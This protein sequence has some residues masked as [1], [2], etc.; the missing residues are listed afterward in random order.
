MVRLFGKRHQRNEKV[1]AGVIYCGDAVFVLCTWELLEVPFFQ[2]EI[3]LQI[4]RIHVI[5]RAALYVKQLISKAGVS[6]KSSCII[7]HLLSWTHIYC[8]LLTW[9]KDWPHIYGCYCHAILICSPFC[10]GS[11]AYCGAWMVLYVCLVESESRRL[12]RLCEWGPPCRD[13]STHILTIS[14]SGLL[15]LPPRF[16]QTPGTR[17]I[18]RGGHWGPYR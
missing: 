4:S 17:L 9:S 18:P 2:T 3:W 5:T 1:S 6:L 12:E 15:T 16:A 11:C 10:L 14:P 13:P 7:K 8:L